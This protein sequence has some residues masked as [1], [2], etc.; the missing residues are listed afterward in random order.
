MTTRLP[1]GWRRLKFGA[2][3]ECVNDR[4]DD[5]SAAG[6]DRYVGLEHLDADS[7]RIRRWGSPDQ[8]ASTKLR[9]R[10]GDIVFGKRRAYQRKLAVADF[11][12]ICSAHAMVLRA[13]PG[14]VY[15][16]FLPFFMQSDAFMDRAL[17]ISVGSLSPTINWKTLAEEEFALPPIEGQLRLARVL[18]SCCM[19]AEAYRDAAAR[20]R[21]VRTSLEVRHFG[22]SPE[23]DA[24]PLGDLVRESVLSFQTGPFGT[25]LKA[26]A[27]R[28][29]G[30]PVVN[31][32]NMVGN[33]LVTEDGP[34]VSDGDWARLERYWLA[35]GDLLLGRKRHMSKLVYVREE[36]ANALVGSDCIRI[37]ASRDV[38]CP[39]YL[40]HFLRSV[41]VQGWLQ[42]QAGGNGTV[43]PGMNERILER[44]V[45]HLPNLPI[46]EQVSEEID[47]LDAAYDIL[48]DRTRSV[49]ELKG[50]MLDQE[51]TERN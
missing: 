42:A 41:P 47:R 22:S 18:S 20:C 28:A 33:L 25:V 32:I 40:F 17:A 44:L 50:A 39:R 9:F 38:V 7:L 43:M 51:M 48:M 36:H 4:V 35:E 21:G 1:S 29:Q 26:S 45:M 19:A 10:P 6:V 14:T 2:I 3:A 16:E 8:V 15:P 13:R 49:S 23:R 5:P 31:P 11:E 30:H 34:F 37:R 24:I 46:Q 27:Y 12:G